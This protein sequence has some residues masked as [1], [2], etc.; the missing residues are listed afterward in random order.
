MVALADRR[1][2]SCPEVAHARRWHVLKLVS[3]RR[4]CEPTLVVGGQPK[5][6]RRIKPVLQHHEAVLS[7]SFS[8]DDRPDEPKASVSSS[9]IDGLDDDP[10]AV[11]CPND[12]ADGHFEAVPVDE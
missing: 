2:R 4:P 10:T 11:P 8:S 6:G 12:S 3:V 5:H 1:S 9:P 7:R